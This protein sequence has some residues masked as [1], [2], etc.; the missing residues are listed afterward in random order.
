MAM[1]VN[2]EHHHIYF[3]TCGLHQHFLWSN[4]VCYQDLK[5]DVTHLKIDAEDIRE[6][7]KQEIMMIE[8]QAMQHVGFLRSVDSK[9]HM[10][11][12]GTQR[13]QR[14]DLCIMDLFVVIG[15]FL[16]ESV[17]Y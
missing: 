4:L 12:E 6:K 17:V 13:H 14:C 2:F 5:L 15:R 1:Y 11:S 10:D 9:R 3:S 7:F 16:R 8:Q